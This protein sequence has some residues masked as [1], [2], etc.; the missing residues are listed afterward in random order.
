[1]N[2]KNINSDFERKVDGALKTLK[3][4]KG[5]IVVDNY[6]KGDSPLLLRYGHNIHT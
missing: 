1:M 5:V 2:Q 4:G 6:D 3:E